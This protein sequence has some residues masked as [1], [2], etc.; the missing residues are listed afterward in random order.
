MFAWKA[1]LLLLLTAGRAVAAAPELALSVE[2]G[3]VSY[4][5]SLLRID[6]NGADAAGCTKAQ[7]YKIGRAHV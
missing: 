1:V 5:R 3:K 6:C 7:I 2:N 4:D